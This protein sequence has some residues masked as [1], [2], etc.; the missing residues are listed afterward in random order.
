MK[1]LAHSLY[2]RSFE[3]GRKKSASSNDA[4]RSVPI[5]SPGIRVARRKSNGRQGDRRGSLCVA[6]LIS[7]FV[8]RGGATGAAH[9]IGEKQRVQGRQ[10]SAVLPHSP[11][12]QNA[13]VT[14]HS[15]RCAGYV[16]SAL[17]QAAADA[18]TRQSQSSGA[19]RASSRRP[20]P[21]WV[22]RRRPKRS[23]AEKV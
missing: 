11:H 2:R 20:S 23:R 19:K 1:S 12:F 15:G 13:F 18:T 7:P 10:A 6:L 3:T 8:L 22:R 9:L 5:T 14:Q 21:S 17:S 16:P 4:N